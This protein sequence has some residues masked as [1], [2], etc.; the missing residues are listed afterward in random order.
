MEFNSNSIRLGLL[1]G[2]TRGRHFTL[3]RL[4]LIFSGLNRIVQSTLGFFSRLFSPRFW[5]PREW[6]LHRQSQVNRIASP[7]VVTLQGGFAEPIRSTPWSTERM[8][9][10]GNRHLARSM[11]EALFRA[12]ILD[13]SKMFLGNPLLTLAD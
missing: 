6:L 10:Q 2:N 9:V 5:K 13:G 8:E 4:L 3:L 1:G 11:P 12:T 7:L